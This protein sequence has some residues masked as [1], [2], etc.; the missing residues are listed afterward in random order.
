MKNLSIHVVIFLLCALFLNGCNNFKEVKSEYFEKKQDFSVLASCK[1]N[2]SDYKMKI[3]KNENQIKLTYL[4]PKCVDGLTFL[5]DTEIDSASYAGLEMGKD[6]ET[7]FK[8][9]TPAAISK[10]L[11]DYMSKPGENIEG[12]TEYGDY[13]AKVDK[14]SGLPKTLNLKNQNFSCSFE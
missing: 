6:S 8:S 12:K 9:T 7:L 14:K 3:E 10:A 1:Q 2:M 11:Q 5:F 13:Q 4:S